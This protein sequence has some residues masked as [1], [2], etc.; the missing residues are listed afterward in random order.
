VSVDIYKRNGHR[1]HKWGCQFRGETVTGVVDSFVVK[2]SMGSST[3]S[4]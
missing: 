2:L 1:G 3:V 4:W